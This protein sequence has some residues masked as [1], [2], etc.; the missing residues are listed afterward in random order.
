[1]LSI[2]VVYVPGAVEVRA[3][4]HV[5][6]CE[7]QPIEEIGIDAYEQAVRWIEGWEPPPVAVIASWHEWAAAVTGKVWPD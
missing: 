7:P 6:R 5:L 3:G 1:M 4:D 2:E